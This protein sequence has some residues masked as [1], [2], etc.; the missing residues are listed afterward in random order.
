MT[1]T[2]LAAVV[3]AAG[4]GDSA[5]VSVGV[6]VGAEVDAAGGAV[7]AVAGVTDAAGVF[8]EHPIRLKALSTHT[9]AKTRRIAE[10]YAPGQNLPAGSG[11]GWR[12]RPGPG[13]V[14]LQTVAMAAARGS[15]ETRPA[16]AGALVVT[17]LEALVVVPLGVPVVRK[18]IVKAQGHLYTY[19]LDWLSSSFAAPGW[20]TNGTAVYVIGTILTAILTV[21]AIGVL[22]YLA[23][24]ATRPVS[25]AAFVPVWGSIVLGCVVVGVLRGFVIAVATPSILH[26]SSAGG[27]I[28]SPVRD[29]ALHGLLVGLVWAL[30][31]TAVAGIAGRRR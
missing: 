18:T 6:A 3:V 15:S 2:R 9:V 1:R 5:G 30:I 12:V 24:Y 29:F 11:G 7:A 10:R 27:V 8:A 21:V 16:F 13:L 4:V 26:S 14:S 23:L 17:I 20:R 19:G 22:T 31:A 25:F 28:V